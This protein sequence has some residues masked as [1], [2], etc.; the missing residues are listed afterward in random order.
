MPCSAIG[1]K[2]IFLGKSSPQVPS[3]QVLPRPLLENLAP[4]EQIVR[5]RIFALF[6][7]LHVYHFTPVDAYED[8]P[9]TICIREEGI[10][11]LFS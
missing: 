8:H 6:P 3:P 11:T 2:G 10:F 5:Y 9:K 4:R 7:W 1:W